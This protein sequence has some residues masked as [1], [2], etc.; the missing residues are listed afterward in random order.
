MTVAGKQACIVGIGE[1]EYRRWGGFLDRSELS[2]ACEAI[3]RA[4]ADAGL[5]VGQIDGLVSYAADRNEPSYLQDSLG[6]PE[7][8]FATMAWGAGE[9]APALRCCRRS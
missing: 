3:K 1:T 7:L 8:R 9:R 6:L 2:L 4:V 5:E